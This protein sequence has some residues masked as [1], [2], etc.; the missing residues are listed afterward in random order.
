MSV[1][2]KQAGLG[3]ALVATLLAAWH[4]PQPGADDGVVLSDR[5]ARTAVQTVAHAAVSPGA[6]RSASGRADLIEIRAR[7]EDDASRPPL[8]LFAP[9]QW[10]APA[11]VPVQKRAAAVPQAAPVAQA[12][13]LPFRALGRYEEDGNVVFFLQ[14]NDQNLV[15]RL[16]DTIAADYKVESLQDNLLTLRHLP[17][18]QSQTL[19]VGGAS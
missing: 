15:V 13:A 7:G 8:R 4:A 19:D 11:S 10:S 18:N 3:V 14:H 5:I 16:G 2:F 9:Q 12:P 17:S 1:T 6:T